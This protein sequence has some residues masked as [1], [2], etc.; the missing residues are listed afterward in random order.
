[1]LVLTVIPANA[2]PSEPRPT[3]LSLA[4]V[5]ARVDTLNHQA[6]Q[7]AERFND[8][9]VELQEVQAQLDR[10]QRQV[11]TAQRE[12]ADAQQLLGQFAAARYRG[13]GLDPT[14]AL[15]LDDDP[16]AFLRQA[17]AVSELSRQQSDVLTKVTTSAGRLASLQAEVE[18]R[19]AARRRLHDRLEAQRN[20]VETK[21]A[22]AQ[23]LLDQLRA[24]ERA[25]LVRAQRAAAQ[26]AREQARHARELAAAAVSR[27]QTR[28][29]LGSDA[30]PAGQA[31]SPAPA[32]SSGAAA[33][34]QFAYAQLGEP[35][36]W[37]AAG[38]SSWDCSGLTMMAWQAAGVSLPHSS[39]AQAAATRPVSRSELQ[40][41]D[42]VFFYSP[43]SHV[44]I[45][46]GGGQMIDAPHPGATVRITSISTM[47]FAGAGRP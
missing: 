18:D 36:V 25:R 29:G 30:Q 47:P 13:A 8:A 43:I 22:A 9:R 12:V 44:G 26:E 41:G 32:S 42:L 39:A 4:Q 31:G 38:P 24:E 34:V 35:Y 19:L 7:A 1:M 2:V 10:V 27:S 37:A 46:I 40:P 16:E 45:Y 17:A 15:L 23:K 3:R 21:L 11:A 28:A 5:Q 14:V 6:E 33:A 20:Q